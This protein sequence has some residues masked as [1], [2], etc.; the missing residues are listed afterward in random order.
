MI[1]RS[2]LVA[3]VVSMVGASVGAAQDKP[4]FR[5][6][7]IGLDTSHVVAFTEVLNNPANNYGCKVVAGYPGG[8][9]DIKDSAGRVQGFTERLRDK[10]GVEIVD[11]IETL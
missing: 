3:A 1:R 5:I 10:F 7:M 9:P 4:V 11:S 6:G 8:S 2:L